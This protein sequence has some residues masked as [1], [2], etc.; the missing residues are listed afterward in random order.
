MGRVRPFSKEDIPEVADLHRRVFHTG[1]S[2]SLEL[3]QAYRS[4]FTQIFLRPPRPG[5]PLSSLV[6]EESN[7]KICGFLGVLPRPMSMNGRPVQAAVSSQFIV[8]P[9]RRSTLA[10]VQL[11]K[12]F[13]SG[14][15]ELSIA[16]EANDA[17][18]KL[19]E[20]CGGTTALLYSLYWLHLLQPSKF[21]LSRFS[22]LPAAVKGFLTPLCLLIDAVT[23]RMPQSPF[24]Q[25]EPG[26]V[27]E[28]LSRD[29]LFA[30][31]EELSQTCSLRPQYDDLSL[32]WLFDA[33]AR[34]RGHGVVQKIAVRN[35]ARKIV[36]WYLYHLVPGGMGEVLQIGAEDDS[37]GTVLDHLFHHAWRQG[38][39]ALSGR[40]E[41]RFMNQF[42]EKNSQFHH[43]GYWVLVHSNNAELLQAIHGGHAFLTR[44]E[45]EWCMRFRLNGDSARTT[46][47]S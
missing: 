33:L 47:L 27:G 18:R 30:C 4:Y 31:M 20:S 6:Y 45:G 35:A 11:L 22:K 36:G 9:A 24:R 3:E 2:P 40:I 1:A 15:Q 38:A 44:L 25:S 39:T 10:G 7:G 41:P 17:S 43:R 37:I 34:D 28:D 29:T 19:W 13:L 46:A 16:D 5:R 14:P 21:I 26:V 32:Q 23:A 12:T 8:D 42:R